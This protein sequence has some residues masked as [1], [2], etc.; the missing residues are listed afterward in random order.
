MYLPSPPEGAVGG[1]REVEG[2]ELLVSN[3]EKTGHVRGSV[4]DAG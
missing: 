2:R 4:V 3:L 1:R